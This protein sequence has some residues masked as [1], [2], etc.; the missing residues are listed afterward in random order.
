MPGRADV[1][2]ALRRTGKSSRADLARITGLA[3]STVTAI[4]AELLADGLVTETDQFDSGSTGAGRPATGVALHRSA[5]VVVGV[6]LGKRHLQVAVC[7]LAHHVL[8]ERQVELP[9]NRSADADVAAAADMVDAVLSTARLSREKVVGVGVGIPGPLRADTGRLGDT[10]SL[11]GWVGR[12]APS[13]FERAL[14]LPVHVDNDAN[15]GALAE[16]TWGAGRGCPDLVY[17]KVSTGIGSGMLFSG[18]P[19]RGVGGTAGEFGHLAIDPK[20]AE[21]RCGNRGCLENLAGAQAMAKSLQPVF[22]RLLATGEIIAHARDGDVDCRR[23]IA[24]AGRTIGTA[25]GVLCNLVNPRRIIVGGEVGS[26]G[27]LLLD[28]MRETLEQT[29]IR[30]AFSDVEVMAAELGPRAEVLGALVLALRDE[31]TLG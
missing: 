11:P 7:D 21:C 10:A 25:T 19:F 24:D 30:S 17:L 13:T 15:L 12:D 18:R 3:P 9:R 1:V 20:G 6:D 8:A 28:S 2:A 14:G 22:G 29:A 26:A 16:W 27:D 23:V 5:G 4:V 31:A